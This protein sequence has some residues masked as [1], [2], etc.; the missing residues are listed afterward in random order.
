MSMVVE[1]GAKSEQDSEIVS[2]GSV[3]EKQGEIN[4]LIMS[5]IIEVKECSSGGLWLKL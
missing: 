1:E 5:E 4:N 2:E 3:K